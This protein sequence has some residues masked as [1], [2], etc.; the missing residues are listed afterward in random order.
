MYERILVLSAVMLLG[1][2]TQVAAQSV[3][4]EVAGLL[5]EGQNAIAKN[6]FDD[7]I[8][9]CRAGLDKLGSAYVRNDILDDSGL[10]LVAADT[11]RREGK[12]ENA[13]SMYCG[14]LAA[15]FEQFIG[16]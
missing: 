6:R 10:K 11:L 14:M 16:K 1:M 5:R 2:S 7:A 3:S 9:K 15:R 12:A 4:Q 8:A 13:S